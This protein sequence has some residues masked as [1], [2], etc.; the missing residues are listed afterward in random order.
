MIS[1]LG[2]SICALLVA[3]VLGQV[4][5]EP[6]STSERRGLEAVAEQL[7][8]LMSTLVDGGCEASHSYTV[9]S[10]ATGSSVVMTI[11]LGGVEVRSE[12]ALATILLCDPLHLWEWD[13]TE[14]NRSMVDGLDSS[15]DPLVAVSGDRLHIAV[16]LVPVQGIWT[17][18]TFV[19]PI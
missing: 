17:T 14:L 15:S 12:N 4:L 18:M 1:K 19:R 6:L 8:D 11:R 16:L 5:N 3:S 13:G 9:P 2:L 10:L 7:D